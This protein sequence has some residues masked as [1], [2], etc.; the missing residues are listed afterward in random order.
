MAKN[1]RRGQSAKA[2]FPGDG[3]MWYYVL[4]CI[5][6]DDFEKLSAD[7]VYEQYGVFDNYK[8]VEEVL[9]NK[10]SPFEYEVTA[11]AIKL[12]WWVY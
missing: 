3:T 9:K 6:V 11:S 1:N 2:H 7:P 12:N 8:A 10:K 4:K 5:N